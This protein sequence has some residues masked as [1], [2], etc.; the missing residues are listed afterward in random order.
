MVR[1]DIPGAVAS[2]TL[3]R[4]D[5]RNALTP[6]MLDAIPAL[7]DR[8]ARDARAIV[9][10]GEG[11]VFCAGFDLSLCRDD[12]AGETMRSLLRGLSTAVRSLR[13]CRVPVVA[14]AHG[15]AIAGGCALL[16]GADFVITNDHARLGYPVL[17][18][19]VSP[20]VSAPFLRATV[21]DAA[22]RERLLDS[23]LISGREAERIGLAHHSTTD[24]EA[25]LPTAMELAE[26]LTL[27]SAAAL[28][29][30]K[31]WLNEID[32]TGGSYWPGM[33]LGAS[34]GLAGGE[35]ERSM[36]PAAWTGGGKS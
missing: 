2:I 8:A 29:A 26:S 34:L 11:R 19:G 30:T 27:K 28:A 16:G 5:R 7:V 17:L 22:C 4:P 24:P 13:G 36:L 10:R 20:A 21:G 23:A 12:P 33:A 14:A 9:L 18:L 25:V 31:A 32:G 6:E 3:D 15:A 35:E 1:L